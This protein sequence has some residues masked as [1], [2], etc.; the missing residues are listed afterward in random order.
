VRWNLRVVLICIS[1][2]VKDAEHFFR[3]LSSI[4]YSSG[5]NS[6]VWNVFT[7]KI[8]FS[9]VFLNRSATFRSLQISRNVLHIT[10]IL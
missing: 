10:Y 8:W 9:V 6:T 3:C 5:Q 4:Q 2:M 7:Q 1:L